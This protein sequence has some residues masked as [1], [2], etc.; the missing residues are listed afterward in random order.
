MP[1]RFI[2]LRGDVVDVDLRGHVGVEKQN[3]KLANSRPCVVVQNDQ[4]NRFSD[5]TIVVPLNDERQNKM[6]PVQVAV[7]ASDLH[8]NGA[9]DS[10]IECGH[11]YTIDRNQRIVDHRGTVSPHVMDKV[12]AKLIASLGLRFID[13]EDEP[14]NSEDEPETELKDDSD[15]DQFREDAD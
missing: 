3:D 9:K 5:M 1:M 7:D 2:I 15:P 14:E 4:G 13:E 12:D 8:I 10:V 11:I 6:L